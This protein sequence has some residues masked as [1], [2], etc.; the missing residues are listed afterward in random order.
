MSG[1][2]GAAGGNGRYSGVVRPGDPIAVE[3]PDGPHVP[4]TIV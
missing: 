4:L 2:V 3:L 1:P